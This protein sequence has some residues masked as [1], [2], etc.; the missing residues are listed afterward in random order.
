[1]PED[2]RWVAPTLSKYKNPEELVRGVANLTAT[3]GKK[4]LLPLPDNAPPEVK[5]ERKALLDSFNGVP[6]EPKDYGIT[7]EAI[8]KDLPESQWNQPLADGFV[9]WAHENSVSP[10]AAKKLI[11][12]QTEAVKSQLAAQEQYEQQFV[13][14]Q[15]KAF[16]TVVTR[17][18]IAADKANALVEKGAIALGL[19]INADSTKLLLRSADA[20][21]MAMRHAIAT[22]EDSAP[23]GESPDAAANDPMALASDIAHNKANPLYEAYYNQSHP[24]HRS[25]KEKVEGYWRQAAARQAKGR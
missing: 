19:D 1:L 18:G 14:Q 23:R 10:A 2:V 4:G 21:L 25:V 24:Q 12:L 16:A 7:R 11:A 15:D 13:Q 20:R 8:A 22:G 5:A 3:V 6:K 9:K 17:E